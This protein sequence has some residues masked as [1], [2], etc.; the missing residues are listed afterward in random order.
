MFVSIDCFN[1][2]WWT[3]VSC[4]LHGGG[5]LMDDY[6][7][8]FISA[9]IALLWFILEWL[10]VIDCYCCGI[11][12]KCST[13]CLQSVFIFGPCIYGSC[14]TFLSLGYQ[15]NLLFH[16]MYLFGGLVSSRDRQQFIICYLTYYLSFISVLLFFSIWSGE[17]GHQ[18]L[19]CHVLHGWCC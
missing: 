6:I 19:W 10:H 2:F 14:N 16:E 5:W 17:F 15:P 4:L 8:R 18:M 11:N 1:I 7:C 9:C 13:S 12:I 3:A